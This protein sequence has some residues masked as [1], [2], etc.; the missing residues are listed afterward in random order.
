M[1]TQLEL[2]QP[3][4]TPVRALKHLPPLVSFFSGAGFFDLG[5]IRAGFSVA[6]SL[7]KDPKFCMAHDE[8]FKSYFDSTITA[9]GPPPFINCVDDIQHKGPNAIKRE[10]FGL[11]STGCDFGIVG[12]PPC[13][14][15]SVGGKNRGQQGDRGRLTRVFV[16]RI[17]ELEPQFFLIENVKGLISTGKHREFLFAEL[18]KLEQKGYAVDHAVLNA[19]ELGVPQDR[20][21]LFI[22]GIKRSL[23]KRLYSRIIARGQRYWFPW[24]KDHRFDDAKRRFQWPSTSPFGSVPLKPKGLPEQL[25]VGPLLLDQEEISKLPNGT[26]GFEP[27][28]EKFQRIA[29]GDDSRKCFKRLH[30]YR[31]SPTAAYGNNEVHL[32]PSLP[33]RLTVR[34]ALRLQTVPDTFQ[35]PSTLTLSTK[36]KLT[37]NGVPVELARRV[38][39]ALGYFLTGNS[40]PENGGLNR[41]GRDKEQ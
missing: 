19:L 14:D 13:P 15:F 40:A 23:I 21:R 10:A 4:T 2:L 9:N 18:W 30:R 1:A 11:A 25:L 20:Q 5:L 41:N 3:L 6:W 34:E 16:E 17:C 28:S 33:R 27:Y 39:V 31:Y 29:E 24:P 7:E 12:G 35:L 32:H 37:G 38:G 22:I 26:E 36:F 8:G